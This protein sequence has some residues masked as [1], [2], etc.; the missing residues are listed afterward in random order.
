M[1]ASDKAKLDG[2]ILGATYKQ[3]SNDGRYAEFTWSF[4]T[5]YNPGL[6]TARTPVMF[7]CASQSAAATIRTA[8]LFVNG[9]GYGG[10]GVTLSSYTAKVD[11]GSSAWAMCLA[12]YDAKEITLT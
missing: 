5:Q 11:C 8:T 4:N 7:V 12:I 10:S 6:A 9:S 1:S 2:V 3:V